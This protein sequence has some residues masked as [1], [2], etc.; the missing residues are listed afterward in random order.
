M[1][2]A[3]RLKDWRCLRL[4]RLSVSAD[5]RC[6]KEQRQRERGARY[7]LGFEG[8][9]GSSW[10]RAL[11]STGGTLGVDIFLTGAGNIEIKLV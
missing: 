10:C 7:R 4:A 1:V 6:E 2:V 5:R 8:L 11:R 3:D 9:L